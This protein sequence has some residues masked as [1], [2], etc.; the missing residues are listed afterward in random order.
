MTPKIKINKKNCFNINVPRAS[1]KFFIL[2]GFLSE[3]IKSALEILV[4]G[5]FYIIV[6]NYNC[7][8]LEL[9]CTI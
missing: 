4:R 9:Q 6:L 8:I 5:R 1:F 3:L 2:Q 7:S